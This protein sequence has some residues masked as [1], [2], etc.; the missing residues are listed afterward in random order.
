MAASHT[1]PSRYAE[2]LYAVATREESLPVVRREMEYLQQQ[3]TPTAPLVIL[4]HNRL[5][6]AIQHLTERLEALRPYLHKHT[7]A[8]LM[9]LLAKRRQHLLLPAITVFLAICD[10]QAGIDPVYVATAVPLTPTVRARLV[11]IA[12]QMLPLG[13]TPK[14]HHTLRPDLIGGYTMQVGDRRYDASL[15]HTLEALQQHWQ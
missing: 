7:Y 5:P 10:R 15:Q 12:T 11:T 14:L 2:A 13:H 6:K 1:L 3:L 9:L 4:L 8:F